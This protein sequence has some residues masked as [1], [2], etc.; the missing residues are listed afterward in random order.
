VKRSDT[1]ALHM[2]TGEPDRTTTAS[3][4]RGLPAFT[5]IELLVVIAII[6]IL[7]SL[8]LPALSKARERANRASCLSN[9]K[10]IGIA[11]MMYADDNR[12][13]LVP[14]TRGATN[15]LTADDDISHLYS[16]YIPNVRTFCCPSTRNQISLTSTIIDI[17]TGQ[18]ILRDLTDNA[19]SKNATNGHSYEVLGE[20]RGN[21]VTQGFVNSYRLSFNSTAM[22]NQPGPSAFWLFFDSD[23]AAPNNEP[24]DGDNHGRVGANVAYCDGH[25]G[26]VSRKAWRRQWNITRDANLS[27]PLP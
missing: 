3:P 8:L 2:S 19:P 14:N 20:I 26:W 9:L 15:R 17:T 12:N 1:F 10:Q 6:A 5:L 21:K 13:E 27:D 23:D 4:F 18:R 25:A 11:T 24:D 22:G 7:A 16:A